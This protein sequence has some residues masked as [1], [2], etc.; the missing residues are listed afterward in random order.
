[1]SKLTG[2]KN[3]STPELFDQEE[4]Q[5]QLLCLFLSWHYT[6]YIHGVPTNGCTIM[7]DTLLLPSQVID[8]SV[9]VDHAAMNIFIHTLFV[10]F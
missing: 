3:I 9:V 5:C 10:L 1:M 2:T 6:D 4:G 8:K 7:N